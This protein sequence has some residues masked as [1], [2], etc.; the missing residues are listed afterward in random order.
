MTQTRQN[1]AT[2]AGGC[3]WCMVAPFE[4]I[5]GVQ[6]VISGFSGGHTQAPSYEQVCAG[7]TGHLEAVQIQYDPDK[8]DYKTLLNIFWQQIDPTD[9]GGSFFDRGHHYTSAIFYHDAN[10]Q[11]IAQASKQDIN[12]SSRFKQAI[13]TDILAYKNFYPAEAYHQ[14]YHKKNPAH[15]NQYRIASGRDSFILKVWQQPISKPSQS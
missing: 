5:D 15:Y 1:F 10:Q 12:T 3:F 11:A 8:V 4:N 6:S 2:F 13:V 9:A 7:G 14:S